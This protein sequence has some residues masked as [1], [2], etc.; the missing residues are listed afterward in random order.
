MYLSR[1]VLNERNSAVQQDLS[2]A[3]NLH[4]RIMQAF[5]DEQRDR[6]RADWNVLFRQEPDSEIVLVQSAIEPNWTHLPSG[7]LSDRTEQSMQV[8]PFEPQAGC[9]Q[10]GTPLQFRLKANPSKRDKQTHKLIGLFHLSDQLA[11][12]ERQAA[13]RGFK[14]LHVDAIPTSGVFG[15]KAKGTAPVQIFTVLFQGVLE[16]TDSALFIATIH[17]GVGRGRSYGCGLLSIAR[18]QF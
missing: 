14:L 10:P 11:W 7:Y 16:I 1:L 5:P 12:L 18:I 17:Q 2:N 6:P 9:L 8:K 3:H 13:Q 4:R 15:V